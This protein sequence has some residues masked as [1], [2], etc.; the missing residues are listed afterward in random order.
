MNFETHSD[1]VK[2]RR[3]DIKALNRGPRRRHE[4]ASEKLRL[5]S[6]PSCGTEACRVCMRQ[7]RL[8]WHGEAVKI[9]IQRPAWTRCSIVPSGMLIDYDDLATFDLA[10]EVK[11]IRKRLQRSSFLSARIVLGGVDVSLN[12]FENEIQGWQFHLYVLVE[13]ADDKELRNAVETAFPPEPLAVRPYCFAPV[14]DYLQVAG[15]AYK[16]MLERR[17]SWHSEDGD[18]QSSG[19][20]LKRPDLR[21]LL[22]FLAKNKVGARLILSGVRR[23][24]RQLVFTDRAAARSQIQDVDVRR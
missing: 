20:P 1:A 22:P 2:R 10:A 4:L 19:L 15:Y 17:S 6:E 23:N 18:L 13:G 21:E 11:K 9:M 3:N 7:F 16:A 8:W 24:G 5:C 12:L 14:K